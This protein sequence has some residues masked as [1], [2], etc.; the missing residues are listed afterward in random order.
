MKDQ[1]GGIAVVRQA[2]LLRAQVASWQRAGERVALI[3]T[4]GALHE[5]HLAL[6]AR[7]RAMA[8]RAVVS[9][10]VNPTQFGPNEDFARYPRDEAGDA[11]KLAAAGTDL[12]YAP[13]VEDMYPPGF[14]TKIDPG[15]IADRQCGPFRPGHFTGVA[16]VVAKLLLQAGA[17]IACFGEKDY[18]QLQV[19]RH[20]VSNL[21]I[22][23][24][25]E[26]VATIRDASGLALSSRNA[27]LT[28]AEKAVAPSLYR[29]L[30]LT[31]RRLAQ[32]DLDPASAIE[33]AEAEL[34]RAG[35]TRIDYL[36][37]ADA[38]TL[39]PLDR[40]DRPARLLAAAWLG[41]TRLIDN[42]AVT[43]GAVP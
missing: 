39:A 14:S 7:G 15:P 22:P 12:L 19:I 20:I 40:L 35:F 41:R 37:L 28:A 5:G 23:T 3:P 36:D 13:A 4:M 2:A 6:V 25:I 38:V 21:D 26:G 31:A 33:I 30:T 34:T 1:S 16:T 24:R 17:D 18:Q 9:I 32:G 10:F 43:R 42:I 11:A 27:Y 29:I 8:T